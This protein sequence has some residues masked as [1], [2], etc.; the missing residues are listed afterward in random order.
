[1]PQDGPYGPRP[2]RAQGLDIG[3][4]GKGN[5]QSHVSM[6]PAPSFGR[7]SNSN[8]QYGPADQHNMARDRPFNDVN[9]GQQPQH[10]PRRAGNDPSMEYGS[11]SQSRGKINQDLPRAA[12]Q[13]S[14]TE[15]RDAPL[16]P[17]MSGPENP[18]SNNRNNRSQDIDLAMSIL[19]MDAGG[20]EPSLQCR[21]YPRRQQF[22]S[23]QRARELLQREIYRL[24]DDHEDPMMLLARSQRRLRR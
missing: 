20:P 14:L 23:K 21:S 5:S 22:D 18:R 1:M 9:H 3:D 11:S 8:D 17:L 4:R 19:T 10:P 12:H 24:A 15:F 2:P 6:Q 13:P 16:S 7:P